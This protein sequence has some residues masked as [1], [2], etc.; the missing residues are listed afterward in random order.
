MKILL[1]CRG[2][3]TVH[4]T[5]FFSVKT[6]FQITCNEKPIHIELCTEQWTSDQNER[7]GK[8]LDK[9]NSILINR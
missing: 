3:L 5:I 6:E 7:L 2:P 1:S 9:R 4:Y 8:W